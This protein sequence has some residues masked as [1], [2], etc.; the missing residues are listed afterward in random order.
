MRKQ[1]ITDN[2]CIW[3]FDNLMCLTMV[4]VH[5]MLHFYCTKVMNSFMQG[6]A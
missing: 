6:Y 5:V 1:N 4:D 3:L 2:S